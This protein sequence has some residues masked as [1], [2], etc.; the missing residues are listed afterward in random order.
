MHQLRELG[1]ST[2]DE[3][4]AK[5]LLSHFILNTH[6]RVILRPEWVGSL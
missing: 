1:Q 5:A 3:V 4:A 2:G 6:F